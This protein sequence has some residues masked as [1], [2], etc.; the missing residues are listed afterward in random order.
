MGDGSWI[1]CQVCGKL[2]KVKTDSPPEDYLFI[3]EFCPR[4]RDETTHLWCG[5]NKEDAYLYGN[6][7]LDERYFIY[8][9]NTK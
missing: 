9:N 1:Q 2:H 7:N 6:S 4:C 5:E 8:N 3:E